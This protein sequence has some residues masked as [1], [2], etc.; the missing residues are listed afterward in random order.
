MTLT[1]SHLKAFEY[2]W[3]PSG[4]G[5][6]LAKGPLPTPD[7]FEDTMQP[8]DVEHDEVD[9]HGHRANVI[10]DPN[11]KEKWLLDFSKES[12]I[13]GTPCD[14]EKPFTAGFEKP[15]HESGYLW[16]KVLPAV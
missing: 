11:D 6:D 7:R 15:A 13:S 1:K 16:P 4:D 10:E 2:D 5:D 14:P 8:N 3:C 9:D 12:T